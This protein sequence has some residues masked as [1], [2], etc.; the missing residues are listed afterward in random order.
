MELETRAIRGGGD[1]S[2]Y[3]YNPSLAVAI[4]AAV[5]YGI[6]FVLTFVQWIRF[7]SWV[8][9]IMV[10]ASASMYKTVVQELSY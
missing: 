6:A 7:K 1:V 9:V 3:H 5:L 10:T 8:W 2:Y 4:V